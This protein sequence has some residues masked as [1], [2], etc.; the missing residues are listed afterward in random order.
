MKL[1]L[2]NIRTGEYIGE[3][4]A[5]ANPAN[6]SQYLIPAN[7]TDIEPPA[8][9]DGQIA[10]FNMVNKTWEVINDPRGIWYNID[11][12]QQVTVLNPRHDIIGLTR[13]KPSSK[14]DTWDGEKWLTDEV[15]EKIEITS[16]TKRNKK[17]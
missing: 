7:A 16:K 13:L 14:H 9:E 4:M 17:K 10:L 6:P 12:K 2:F 8:I 5:N 3:K 11:T 1:Y 15:Q